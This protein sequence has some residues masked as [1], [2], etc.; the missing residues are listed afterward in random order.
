MPDKESMAIV[1][2]WMKIV[3]V[4]EGYECFGVIEDE[5]DRQ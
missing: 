5:R 4:H 2:W 1:I 3:D